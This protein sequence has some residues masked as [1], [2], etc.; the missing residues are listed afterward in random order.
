MAEAR[1]AGGDRSGIA[2]GL[3]GAAVLGG[4]AA[5]ALVDRAPGRAAGIVLAVD[6][7]SFLVSLGSIL[8]LP[9][10]AAPAPTGSSPGERRRGGGLLEGLESALRTPLVVQVVPLA[11]VANVA[12]WAVWSLLPMWVDTRWHGAGASYGLLQSLL[13]AGNILG[14]LSAAAAARPMRSPG[15]VFAASVLAEGLLLLAFSW[16]PW[17]ALGLAEWLAFG[18]VSTLGGT[19]YFSALQAAV[20]QE[21]LGRVLGGALT[22]ITAASPAGAAL[23]G[24]ALALLGL[25]PLVHAAGL[26]ILL[27]GGAL[28]FT[29]SIRSLRPF[30]SPAG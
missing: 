15:A 8:L 9:P 13:A 11:V 7:L 24:P 21:E 19:L 3:W 23:S 4:L 2:V 10:A 12:Y 30:E 16:T 26:L 25:S 6:A 1:R 28:L 22:A 5:G 29:P 20:R 17:P 27:C 14:G 18:L